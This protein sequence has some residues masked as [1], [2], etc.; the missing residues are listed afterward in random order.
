MKTID[1]KRAAG[2]VSILAQ[3]EPGGPFSV[4]RHASM[5]DA[6]LRTSKSPGL[7]VHESDTGQ[8]SHR[9]RSMTKADAARIIESHRQA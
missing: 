6:A 1:P 8:I 4:S 9:P 2:Q 3:D 7:W 5:E